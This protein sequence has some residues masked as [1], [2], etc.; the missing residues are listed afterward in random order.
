MF[1]GSIAATPT[2]SAGGSSFYGGSQYPGAQYGRVAQNTRPVTDVNHDMAAMKK[3]KELE[4]LIREKE[5]MLRG[6]K[7]NR[8]DANSTGILQRHIEG[9]KIQLGEIPQPVMV[10]GGHTE[11]AAHSVPLS[12]PS[13][14]GSGPGGRRTKRDEI[15]DLKKTAY[16]RRVASSSRGESYPASC[17]S[18]GLSSRRVSSNPRFLDAAVV[19][20]DNPSPAPVAVAVPVAA[21]YQQQQQAAAKHGRR[22]TPPAT[23]SATA[24]SPAP[25]SQASSSGFLNFG[26]EPKQGYGRRRQHF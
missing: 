6:Y 9:L 15:Y 1:G 2:S 25:S 11:Q 4:D 10:R 12:I 26:S 22:A 23:H 16:L 24:P 18:S 21:H 13:S 17:A 20:A 14:A 3:R 7:A 19:T 8:M 5:D